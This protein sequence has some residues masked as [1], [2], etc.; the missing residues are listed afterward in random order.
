[1]V[2]LWEP[3]FGLLDVTG[4]TDFLNA[5]SRHH[6]ITWWPGHETAEQYHAHLWQ[7]PLWWGIGLGIVFFFLATKKEE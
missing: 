5:F 7:Y 6:S 1:M 3:I 4:I 2:F